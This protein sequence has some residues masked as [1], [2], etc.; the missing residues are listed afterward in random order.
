MRDVYAESLELHKKYRG[1]LEIHSKVPVGNAEDLSLAYS[2]GVA[3]PCLAI[4]DDEKASYDYTNRGN[5]VAV[6]SDGSAVLGLGDIGPNGAL[7]VME[8]KAILFKQFGG[9]DAFPICINVHTAEEIIAFCKAL[10]PTVGGINLEDISFPR[11]VEIERALI[12]D[13]NIPVFHDDQHGTA[14]VA[15]AGLINA[16]KIVGKKPGDLKVVISGTGAAGSSVMRMLHSFG[17]R[18]M[19]AFGSRGCL[20]KEDSAGYDKY[21]MELLDI[22]N[23]KNIKHASLAEALVGADVFMGL[24]AP[25]IVSGDMVGTMAKDAI[26][27]AM[28]NPTPEVMPAVAKAAGARIVGTGRSDFPNQINNVLAFPGLFRGALDARALHITQEMKMAAAE[29]IANLVKDSELTDDYII[30]S[31]FDARVAPA[32]AKAVADCALKTGNVSA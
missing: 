3:A 23:P 12:R 20:C 18:D 28:A 21:K 1:K 30:P 31:P 22:V 19:Y 9:V 8:G 11:C 4:R 2:P 13:M 26:I 32:V 5:T 10:E 16:L 25:D 29:A 7:P 17:V 24:S 14:I 15:L 27:F 6:I